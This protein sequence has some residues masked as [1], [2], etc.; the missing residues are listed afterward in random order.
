MVPTA[1]EI[2]LSDDEAKAKP[3]DFLVAEL[4]G[5]LDTKAPASFDMMAIMGKAGDEKT[6]AT[7]Q[8]V[9][10]DNARA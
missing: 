9:D 6:N 3:A 1:G 10:E 7:E 8:W 5:R 2:G 4:K